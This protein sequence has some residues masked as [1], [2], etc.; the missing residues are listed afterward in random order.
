MFPFYFF[1]YFDFE[2]VVL[3][4]TEKKSTPKN[5]NKVI[6]I[7]SLF[8]FFLIY[9]ISHM[10]FSF[11][12]NIFPNAVCLP[13]FSMISQDWVDTFSNPSWIWLLMKP[14]LDGVEWSPLSEFLQKS[15]LDSVACKW[16]S[17]IAHSLRCWVRSWSGHRLL[18]V[19]LHGTNSEQARRVTWTALMRS[20]I[21][22][23]PKLDHFW[24]SLSLN[25]LGIMCHNTNLK[26]P[27]YQITATS[28]SPC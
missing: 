27:K 14:W 7:I 2:I 25:A 4:K 17:F 24:N 8:C 6:W 12:G 3:L 23:H 16:Q 5:L 15:S 19:L 20:G 22:L 26:I 28:Q 9:S 1:V 13:M 10:A 18:A 11:G 21:S